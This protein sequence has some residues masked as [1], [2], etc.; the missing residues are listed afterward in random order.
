M[1]N[2]TV[3]PDSVNDLNDIRPKNNNLV[4]CLKKEKN[5]VGSRKII[6]FY[7]KLMGTHF[8]LNYEEL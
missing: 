2:L 4:S 7:I 1:N 8:L 6:L 5:D 3:K